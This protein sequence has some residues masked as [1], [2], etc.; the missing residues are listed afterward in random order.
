MYP[1]SNV[2]LSLYRDDEL[3]EHR[4][5]H[6]IWVDAGRLYLSKLVAYASFD[7]DTPE[8]IRRIAHMGLGIGGVRQSMVSAINSSPIVDAYPAGDDPQGTSGNEYDVS[9]PYV[10]IETLERPIRITGGQTAYPGAPADVW[11]TQ[12][13]APGFLIAHDTSYETVFSA[14]FDVTA[15]DIVYGTFTQMPLS[16]MGLF[17]DDSD[18][19]EPYEHPFTPSAHSIERMVAYYQ[20]GTL[21][22]VPGTRLE[23]AWHVQF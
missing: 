22:L 7:A 14:T 10:P 15:G 9:Y 6:N 11:L 21:L 23:V 8:E 17:L 2:S 19:N 4:E 16:E 13:A 1:T 20:F 5:G 3:L 12:K 18:I